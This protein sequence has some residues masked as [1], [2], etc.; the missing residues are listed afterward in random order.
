[1]ASQIL[2]S[3]LGTQ[4]IHVSLG[5]FDTHA[6][7]Q[8]AHAELLSQLSQN[9]SAFLE[10]MRTLGREDEVLVMTYS[11]FGRRVHENGSMGTDHGNA[12][13]MFLLGA[14]VN[15][16]FHGEH[17][18]LTE[19]NEED[20]LAFTTDYRS[21]YASVLEDWLGASSKDIL[22]ERFTKLPLIG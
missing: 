13:P 7:Q 17:P 11:E 3:D 5:G 10:D 22:G 1:M 9:L 16:G 4:V 15:G 8:F 6:N 14:P 18:S 20:N 19:L 2:A 12:A 21:V